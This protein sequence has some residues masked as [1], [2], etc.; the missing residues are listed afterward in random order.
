MDFID[1]GIGDVDYE[2]NNK[3]IID[4]SFNNMSLVAS[5]LKSGYIY[6]EE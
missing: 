3:K 5:K 2:H 4:G 6:F 1:D